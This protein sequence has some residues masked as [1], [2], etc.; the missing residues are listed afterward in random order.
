MNRTR[1][2]IVGIVIL[3]IVVFLAALIV[4][5]R[6]GAVGRTLIQTEAAMLTAI[7]LWLLMLQ[8][9]PQLR[10]QGLAALDAR[11]GV[12]RVALFA[13]AMLGIV[14]GAAIVIIVG[15][16]LFFAVPLIAVLLLALEFSGG[17]VLASFGYH[18]RHALEPT[19]ARRPLIDLILAAQILTVL[20]TIRL[21][22]II[23][24]V[25]LSFLALGIVAHLALLAIRQTPVQ[26]KSLV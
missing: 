2:L 8:F 11:R 10:D 15:R 17:V 12:W 24:V 1:W 22:A 6:S 25:A 14:L 20:V 26:T 7:A 18:L 16:N 3:R 23:A 21:I 19:A 13:L 4:G 5:R 9:L